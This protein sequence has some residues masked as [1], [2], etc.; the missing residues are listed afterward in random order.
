[1]RRPHRVHSI[2]PAQA[3]STNVI[4]PELVVGT[5]YPWFNCGHDFGRSIYHEGRRSNSFQ[6]ARAAREF[7]K[8]R[9]LGLR[10][11]RWWI[12]AGGVNYPPTV[13]ERSHAFEWRRPGIFGQY[14]PR[15]GA[16]LPV[17]DSRFL[18]DFEALCAACSSA[19]LQ[20]IPSLMSFEWFYPTPLLHPTG[21]ALPDPPVV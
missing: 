12:L 17:L 16:A 6:R 4:V 13:A 20:L 18:D 14:Y 11:L 15:R 21:Q 1:M 19:G 2:S 9:D 7:P 8:L 3:G 10:V 5:N